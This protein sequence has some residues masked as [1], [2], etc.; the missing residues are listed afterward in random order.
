MA[1][2]GF[3][4]LIY[5]NNYFRVLLFS[6]VDLPLEFMLSPNVFIAAF[7]DKKHTCTETSSHILYNKFVVVFPFVLSSCLNNE[8]GL[9]VLTVIWC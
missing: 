7:N 1:I 9:L 5:L 8:V 6:L 3:L 2:F 4:C